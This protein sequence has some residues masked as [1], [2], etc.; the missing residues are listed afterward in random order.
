MQ[1]ILGT[2]V[3][4]AALVGAGYLVW[5][6]DQPRCPR[7]NKRLADWEVGAGMCV[8]CMERSDTEWLR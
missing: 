8:D 4:L 2:L 1:E 6:V 3:L 5:A 7:C